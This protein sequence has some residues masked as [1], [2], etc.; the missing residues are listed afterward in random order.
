MASPRIGR[1]L[2]EAGRIQTVERLEVSMALDPYLTLEA[3][4]TYSGMPQRA[5]RR[6]INAA[7]DLALPC[8]RIGT[9]IV[10][11]RSEF[12]RWVEQHRHRGRPSL[13]KAL[14]ELGLR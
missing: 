11:R 1:R 13:E 5:L 4:A 8:Y 9:R 12:D 14:A 6:A 3:L 10:V 7:P 2:G